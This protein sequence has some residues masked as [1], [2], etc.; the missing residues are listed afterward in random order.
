MVM[1]MNK[2]EVIK[3]LKKELNYTEEKCVLINDIAEN[4]FLIG[5][6]NKEKIISE[7]V[8]KLNV[9]ESDANNIY[10]VFMTIIGSGIKDK[11]KHP[12]RDLDK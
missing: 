2:R 3:R 10:E 1:K 4:T 5:K 11:L 9:S 7:F 8:Q 12:F 6:K